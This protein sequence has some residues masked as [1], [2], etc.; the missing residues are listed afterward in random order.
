[1]NKQEAIQFLTSALPFANK[2][3]DYCSTL[4]DT[5]IGSI[6]QL[7]QILEEEYG[8]LTLI[9]RHPELGDIYIVVDMDSDVYYKT[10]SPCEGN[11]KAMQ[12]VYTLIPW[13][14]I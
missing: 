11:F 13:L 12:A 8:E 7:V 10:V 5:V 9:G 4:D 3:E 14:I 2:G 6:N 1:M